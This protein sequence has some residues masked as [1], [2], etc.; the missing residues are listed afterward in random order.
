M[1]DRW[2]GVH[3]IHHNKPC[4]NFQHIH[5]MKIIDKQI[6]YGKEYG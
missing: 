4:V 2:V 1:C 3:T 5:L 6:K